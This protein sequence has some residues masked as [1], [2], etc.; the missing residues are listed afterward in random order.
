M[1]FIALQ[2]SLLLIERL[3]PVMARLRSRQPD[4]HRQIRRAANSV[5]LNLAEGAGR[6]GRDKKHHYRI[7]LGSV[8]EVGAA[9]NAAEAWGDVDPEATLPAHEVLKRLRKL[10]SGLTD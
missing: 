4:L 9:L 1:R 5:P 2:Q 7:A 6:A 10:L 8:Y 3:K